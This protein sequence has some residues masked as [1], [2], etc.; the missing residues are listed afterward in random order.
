MSITS[1]GVKRRNFWVFG[2]FL[3]TFVIFV[4][5]RRKCRNNYLIEMRTNKMLVNKE[6]KFDAAHLLP[7]HKGQCKNLHGHTYKLIV[8]CEGTEQITGTSE[9][10]IMDF[11]DLKSI[12]QTG[13][14]DKFDHAF[15]IGTDSEVEKDV[16][17]VLKKHDLKML[18]LE[19]RSTAENMAKYI[20]SK[21]KQLLVPYKIRLVEIVLFET[22]T[23]FVRCSEE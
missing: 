18:R 4:F 16:A 10:M 19:K 20:F 23:S 22:S 13:I 21:L 3:G 6:F 9:G 5:E 1:K 14:I 7:N 11:S 12:V 15:I 2:N 8:T 17:A